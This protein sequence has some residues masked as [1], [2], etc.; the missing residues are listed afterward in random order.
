MRHVVPQPR[1]AFCLGRGARRLG[2][3]P[4]EPPR[5]MIR[6][7]ALQS[8]RRKQLFPLWISPGVRCAAG[9]RGPG[10]TAIRQ[11]Q[12]PV[13]LARASSVHEVFHWATGDACFPTRCSE[14]RIWTLHQW[15]ICPSV[16]GYSRTKSPFPPFRQFPGPV[17]IHSGSS[18]QRVLDSFKRA[19]NDVAIGPDPAQSPARRAGAFEV[20]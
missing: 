10:I 7:V 19:G 9:V 20:C 15:V 16:C 4:A 6:G 2:S 13:D 18:N 1:A 11:P 17:N 3:A 8:L 14:I 5:D 12:A